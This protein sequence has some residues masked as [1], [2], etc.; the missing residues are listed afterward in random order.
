MVSKKDGIYEEVNKPS[1]RGHYI[2]LHQ[3]SM[4]FGWAPFFQ[5][6]QT[7]KRMPRRALL[8]PKVSLSF[9]FCIALNLGVSP[10]FF[11]QEST[12]VKTSTYGA[13]VCFSP[14]TVKGGEFL[15]AD[16]AKILA[17]LDPEVSREAL[18]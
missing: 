2:G 14:A 9:A 17:D 4:S 16:G 11:L 7:R 3:V 12:H 1:L 10:F 6:R 18:K 5:G 8:N 13:F 15:V